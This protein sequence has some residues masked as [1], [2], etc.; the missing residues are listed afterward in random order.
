MNTMEIFAIIIQLLVLH[1]GDERRV[2]FL[3][4]HV[5]NNLITKTYD[6][7]NYIVTYIYVTFSDLKILR[8][9]F[10]NIIRDSWKK[11]LAKREQEP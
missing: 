7:F 8:G 4:I 1:S 11:R 3:W 10:W 2:R 5:F 9:I 6:S